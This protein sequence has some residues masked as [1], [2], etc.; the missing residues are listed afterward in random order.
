[1][2]YVPTPITS[3]HVLF[4]ESLERRGWANSFT[5]EVMD[6]FQYGLP[7]GVRSGNHF[8]YETYNSHKGIE[9]DNYTRR[10][11]ETFMRPYKLRGCP[12]VLVNMYRP[13]INIDSWHTFN[14]FK[15]IFSREIYDQTYGKYE[16][17]QESSGQASV[18]TS[19]TKKSSGWKLW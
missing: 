6:Y 17:K 12:L 18:E 8:Q 9:Y 19:P 7:N 13:G 5:Y 14:S 4:W 11:I 1:M 3:V 15:E 2:L 16:K 10:F